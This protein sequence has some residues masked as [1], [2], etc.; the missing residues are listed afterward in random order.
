MLTLPYRVFGS[1]RKK[2]LLNFGKLTKCWGGAYSSS[3]GENN[4]SLA[5]DELPAEYFSRLDLSGGVSVS[6]KRPSTF[7]HPPPPESNAKGG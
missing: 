5:Y 4:Q 2:V 1:K 3:R 6:C 7:V